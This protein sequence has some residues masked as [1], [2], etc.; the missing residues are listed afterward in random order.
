MK[1][2]FGVG[3]IPYEPGDNVKLIDSD[4][5]FRIEEICMEQYIVS[6]EIYFKVKLSLNGQDAGWWPADKIE[7]R[8]I[9]K[10]LNK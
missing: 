7:K 3:Y 8:I 6:R 10:D 4:L 5:T 1:K 9:T 2:Q